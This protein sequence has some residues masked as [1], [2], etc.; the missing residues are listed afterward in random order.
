MN[1]SHALNAIRDKECG[2]FYHSQTTSYYNQQGVLSKTETKMV[3]LYSNDKPY[4]KELANTFKPRIVVCE[5]GP[6]VLPEPPT[7]VPQEQVKFAAAEAPAPQ[8]EQA[9]NDI[10]VYTDTV[11]NKTVPNDA[12]DYCVETEVPDT[13]YTKEYTK[14]KPRR[15]LR[16]LVEESVKPSKPKQPTPKKKQKRNSR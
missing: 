1:D 6:S 3:L 14:D 13:E 15:S 2:D 4:D 9:F 11:S 10:A 12:L 7:A 16:L 5:P 8:E